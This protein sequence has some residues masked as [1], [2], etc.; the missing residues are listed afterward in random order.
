MR[1]LFIPFIIIFMLLFL[2]CCKDKTTTNLERIDSTMVKDPLL[3]L[4]KLE[5]MKANSDLLSTS[6]RMYFII[7][8]AEVHDELYENATSDSLVKLATNWY[9]EHGS[10]MEKIRAY[11]LLGS[12]YRDMNNFPKAI[13]WYLRAKEELG[14]RVNFEWEYR[15]ISQLVN[16]YMFLGGYEYSLLYEKEMLKLIAEEKA[17]HN[18]YK[19]E[20][21]LSL[22][23][24]YLF[25]L[26]QPA[27][28]IPYL[29]KASFLSD[30]D[31]LYSKKEWIWLYNAEAMIMLRRYSEANLFLDRIRKVIADTT[32]IYN[33]K[34][35]KEEFNLAQTMYYIN[36]LPFERDSL[37]KYV[38]LALHSTDKDILSDTYGLLSRYNQKIGNCSLAYLYL[39]KQDSLTTNTQKER[40][41]SL[42]KHSTSL[43]DYYYEIKKNLSYQRDIIILLCSIII[44]VIIAFILY[45]FFQQ[46]KKKEELLFQR[47]RRNYALYLQL[48]DEMKDLGQFQGIIQKD[49]KE[50]CYYRLH[51]SDV[52]RRLHQRALNNE[53]AQDLDLKELEIEIDNLFIGFT[54]RLQHYNVVLSKQEFYLC[55]LFKAGFKNKE[56]SILLCTTPSSISHSGERIYEKMMN[57]K[58]NSKS[59]N[60][61]LS[62]I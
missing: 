34:E 10:V 13:D 23:Y 5:D 44:L 62:S 31:S 29:R 33:G 36:H 24:I 28:A 15:I 8:E 54:E 58:G 27:K 39:Q 26:K 21:Y 52:C 61:L 18:I 57:K 38:D 25:G 4:W 47:S 53:K 37:S 51:I 6:N 49:Y 48:K 11:Y 40:F 3:A 20:T 17:P 2:V 19:I 32:K 43:H 42:I 56:M 46:K 50:Q 16:C 1:Y 59:L 9:A 22:G 45:F 60:S 14:D 12:T 41:A 55:L 7:L 30:N 35:F